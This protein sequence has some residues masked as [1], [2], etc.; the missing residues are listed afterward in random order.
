MFQI[1]PFFTVYMVSYY[2]DKKFFISIYWEVS[3]K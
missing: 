3:Q 1:L 2:E